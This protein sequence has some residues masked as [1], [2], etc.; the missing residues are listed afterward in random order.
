MPVLHSFTAL[1]T[2]S[3]LSPPRTDRSRARRRSA[4]LQLA[5]RH[6]EVRVAVGEHGAVVVH[7]NDVLDLLDEL[8]ESGRLSYAGLQRNGDRSDFVYRPVAQTN[9]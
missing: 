8:N 1:P 5:R 7:A 3:S 6:G 2:R 9:I 4:L